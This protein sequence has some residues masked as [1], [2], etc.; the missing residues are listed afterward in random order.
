VRRAA[1]YH[2]GE[3]FSSPSGVWTVT[4]TGR[5]VAGMV[6]LTAKLDRDDRDEWFVFHPDHL[7]RGEVAS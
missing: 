5:T 4:G 2:P 1:D 7:L 6:S 3:R